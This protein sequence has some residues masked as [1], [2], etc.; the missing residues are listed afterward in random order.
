MSTSIASCSVCSSSRISSSC[1]SSSF[2]PGAG[3]KGGESRV[4]RG[5]PLWDPY[6]PWGSLGL[7]FLI[8]HGNAE[9]AAHPS[10]SGVTVPAGPSAQGGRSRCQVLAWGCGKVQ[11]RR[12]NRKGTHEKR[13]GPSQHFSLTY[14]H[15]RIVESQNH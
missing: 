11:G 10:R 14:S 6:V 2:K 15:Q 3:E 12:R 1:T 13:A 7:S 8:P 9:H 4:S 5:T